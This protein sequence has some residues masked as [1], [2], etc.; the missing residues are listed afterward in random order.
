MFN[1]KSKK[2][3]VESLKKTINYYNIAGDAM[4]NKMV[5]LHAIRVVS[6]EVM[7][8]IEV[9]INLLANTPKS[10]EKD[11]HEIHLGL[12]HFYGLMEI[13]YDEKV[14]QR[15]SG[16]G[17]ALGV[18][19]GVATAALA[20]TAALAIATTFGVA[21]TG[22]PI[23]LLSGAAA[24]NAALAWLGGG[25]VIA[26]GGGMAG[27]TALLSLAGPIGWGVGAVT[28]V[29]GGLYANK[30]NKNAAVKANSERFKIESE[31]LL[32]RGF[33]EEMEELHQ[34]TVELS[35]NLQKQFTRFAD[36]TSGVVSFK[37]FTSDQQ[38]EIGLIINITNAL[39]KMINKKIG[40]LT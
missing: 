19:T 13:E 12:K 7:E 1:S 22:T 21:S 40:N 34:K 23:F 37:S 14:A 2:L 15:I 25:A 32:L 4:Q 17:V 31:T 20:P 18:A 10:F 30:K 16:G 24:T 26:G 6:V 39:S 35:T 3:A 11:L 9:Y 29:G 8:N 5:E 28:L 33:I 36:Q 38:K 27:G